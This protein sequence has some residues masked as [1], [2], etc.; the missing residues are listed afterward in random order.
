M[1]AQ[2]SPANEERRRNAWRIAHQYGNIAGWERAMY[3]AQELAEYA[4]ACDRAREASHATLTAD[5]DAWYRAAVPAIAP[6]PCDGYTC[7]LFL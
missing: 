1:S 5:L 4:D 6:E 7:E 3:R 2:R